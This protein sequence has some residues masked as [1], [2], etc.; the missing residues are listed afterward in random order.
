M[1]DRLLSLE[2]IRKE[3]LRVSKPT[4]YKDVLPTLPTVS[5]GRRRFVRESDLRA[6][7]ADRA[8]VEGPNR[9]AMGGSKP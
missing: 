6:W 2:E 4:L 3:R 1:E 5:I 9:K 8:K 7:L